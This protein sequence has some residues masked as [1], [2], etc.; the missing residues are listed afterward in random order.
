MR[1]S[2][3]LLRARVVLPISQSPIENGAVL[4]SGNRIA[5]VGLWKSISAGNRC[6]TIDLGE[7]ILLPGFVNAHCHLDYTDM[8]GR[9]PPQKNFTD[10][11]K[12]ML[13][14][15]SE[16]SRSEYMESW[17]RGAA[18]LLRSGTT[19]VGDFEAVP[20]L[21]PDILNS[22]PLRV[23]SFL[24]MTG[25]KSRRAPAA[26]LQEALDRIE[27]FPKTFRAGLA[28]HAPY[29]TFPE[30]IRLSAR[31]AKKNHLPISIHVSESIQEFEMFARGRGVMFDWLRRG[32]RDMSDCG[33]GSPVRHLERCGALNKNLIAVHVNYLAPGDAALLARR[34]VSVAHCPR[35]HFYF[36]H[37]KFP[38]E[39]LARAKVNVCFG[40]DSLAT[41]YKTR[42]ETVKLNMFE[43]MRAFAEMHPRAPAKRILE[44]ATINGARALG[45]AGKIGE[46]SKGAFADCVA[47]PFSGKISGAHEAA[48]NHTGDVLTSL[49][50]G[51]WAIAPG[52]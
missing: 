7:T 44:M 3:M 37:E 43:E 30:L 14:T 4:I 6:K 25:V 38:F 33:R 40:T 26:I 36:R 46:L 18:M 13:A 21:L 42:K 19:T 1:H 47:I 8:A 48:L 50:G 12:L 5:Q 49:I 28:P 22:T 27:S 45:L 23:I 10:W 16:W 9:I 52:A 34:Q 29:S 35:S 51:K 2:K 41:V 24:E 31:S 15:K 32:E 17:R 20:E 39:K 11:I